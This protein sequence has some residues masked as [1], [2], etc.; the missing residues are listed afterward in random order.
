MLN[1]AF[2]QKQDGVKEKGDCGQSDRVETH[3]PKYQ[4]MQKFIDSINI[5]EILDLHNTSQWDLDGNMSED[6]LESLQ[7]DTD[8]DLSDILDEMCDSVECSI[9]TKSEDAELLKSEL[10]L[11]HV[12]DPETV[13]DHLTFDNIDRYI[14]VLQHRI[15]ALKRIRLLKKSKMDIPNVETELVVDSADIKTSHE[16]RITSHHLKQPSKVQSSNAVRRSV[17]NKEFPTIDLTEIRDT[18]TQKNSDADVMPSS[19]TMPRK[20]GRP[21]GSKT[22]S[23]SQSN[24]DSLQKSKKKK[25]STP[26]EPSNDGSKVEE[27]AKKIEDIEKS[28]TAIQ[29]STRHIEE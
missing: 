24:P 13:R 19:K 26:I 28:N 4:E 12:F 29:N 17:E 10:I 5:D 23:T 22:K 2:I 20:R 14:I 7:I 15:R 27:V 1:Q 18:K 21:K 3:S 9:D 25:V 8:L 11:H 6:N 16:R